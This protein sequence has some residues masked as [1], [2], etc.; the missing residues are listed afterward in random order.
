MLNPC[1]SCVHT[2]NATGLGPR[3][4]KELYASYARLGIHPEAVHITNHPY[5]GVNIVEIDTHLNFPLTPIGS[6]ITPGNS[7]LPTAVCPITS[8]S[9]L[10]DNITR[11]W[12]SSI[13]A[14]VLADFVAQLQIS[15]VSLQAILL[16]PE[17]GLD[18]ARFTDLDLRHKR[19]IGSSEPHCTL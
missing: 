14:D 12:D 7:D 10:Q 5:V 17:R 6:F 1:F 8:S 16:I 3:R 15:T 13:I 11:E 9:D 18:Y 19:H 4:S 2:G